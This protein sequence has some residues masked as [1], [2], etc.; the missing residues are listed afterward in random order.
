MNR[1]SPIVLSRA[2]VPH[3]KEYYD[4]LCYEPDPVAG[5]RLHR[6][7]RLPHV[8]INEDGYRGRSLSGLETILVMG[9]SVT[10]GVGASSDEACFAR[11]LEAFAE[12]PTADASVRA[13]RVFQHFGRLPVLLHRLRS[14]RQVLLWCG[15][16]DLLFWVI[17]G[18]SVEGAFQLAQKYGPASSIPAGGFSRWCMRLGW[19]GFRRP[20]S[21]APSGDRATL[22]EL[23]AQMMTYIRAIEDLLSRRGIRFT[24]L[25]QPFVR[26]RPKE[27]SLRLILDGYDE[28]ARNRCGAGWYELSS[29]FLCLLEQEL[30]RELPHS[31]VDCQ[32]LVSE[33]DFLDQ[34]H[35]REPAVERIAERLT[36]SLWL[37]AISS[38]PDPV[39]P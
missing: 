34:V 4:L 38:K 31:W 11:F 14:L 24:L 2:R 37:R 16:A 33:A 12:E 5:F 13:Y 35:L 39:A 21:S 7:Q 26:S 10:F 3:V 23:V 30:E 36:Q 1:P 29:R 18:G 17:S 28:K 25:L 20:R 9:D 27:P 22:G 19:M 6:N 8:T 15:Y 32:S